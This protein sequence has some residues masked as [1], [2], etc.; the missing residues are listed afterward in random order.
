M[1]QIAVTPLGFRSHEG[2]EATLAEQA[3]EVLE[4]LDTREKEQLLALL[5]KISS[6]AHARTTRSSDDSA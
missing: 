5:S 6:R 4:P 1:T 2:G 3:A